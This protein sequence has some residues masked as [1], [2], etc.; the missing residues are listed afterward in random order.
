MS[1]KNK[2][3]WVLNLE[4]GYKLYFIFCNLCK[5]MSLIE[6]VTRKAEL[7]FKKNKVQYEI[8]ITLKVV[9]GS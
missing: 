8:K 3:S 2:L 5:F 7:F 4:K 9:A 1:E 6:R